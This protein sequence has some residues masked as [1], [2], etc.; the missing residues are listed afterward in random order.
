M[1]P[2]VASRES[3]VKEREQDGSTT[4]PFE[5]ALGHR[6]RTV[7]HCP[8]C[9][10]LLIGVPVL[11]CAHCGQEHPLRA[12]FYSPRAGVYLA[13]CIDLDLISSGDS[14]EAAVAKLQ[15]AMFSYLAA[16]FDG[17]TKGL[18]PRLSPFSHRLRYYWHCFTTRIQGLFLRRH[19][20][21][22]MSSGPEVKNVHF[23]HC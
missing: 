12:F 6:V 9:G 3:K 10:A 21:H 5:E 20:K 11:K 16:A 23:S 4:Q 14:P 8:H 17:P 13:E 22:L 15:E 2:A 19:N 7:R 1:S 18:V